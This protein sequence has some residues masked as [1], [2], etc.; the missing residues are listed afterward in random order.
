MIL[1]VHISD[2][3]K[4]LCFC[5]CLQVRRQHCQEQAFLVS[6]MT[7]LSGRPSSKLALLDV[8]KL[9]LKF[10]SFSDC[11]TFAG[12]NYDTLDDA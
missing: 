8:L 10:K 6:F 5:I 3:P 4:T 2:W 1:H 9:G 12:A 7:N 11:T